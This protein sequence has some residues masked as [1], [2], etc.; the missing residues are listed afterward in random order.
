MAIFNFLIDRKSKTG[1]I[2]QKMDGK[3]FRIFVV[4]DDEWYN[5]LLVHNFP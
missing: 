3:P 2:I 4:E 5:R 1:L